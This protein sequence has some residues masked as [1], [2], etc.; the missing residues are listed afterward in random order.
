MGLRLAMGLRRHAHQPT[1]ASRG[2]TQ[3]HQR[4]LASDHHHPRCRDT[5]LQPLTPPPPHPHESRGELGL[6]RRA[7][8]RRLGWLEAHDEDLRL[9]KRAVA[10]EAAWRR[11]VD[12]RALVLDPPGWLL[13]E[14][15]PVPTDP[16]EWAVWRTAAAE[17]DSYRRVYGLEHDRP[18]KHTPGRV[19]REGWAAA[20]PTAAAGGGPTRRPG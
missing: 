5:A 16:L 20:P 19:G 11:R 14:L 9:Q 17:L 15:G 2:P 4:Q 3:Q 8:Q 13:A 18:A 1:A 6:L 10:R 7:Q 12:Q